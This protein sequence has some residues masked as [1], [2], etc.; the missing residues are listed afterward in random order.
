MQEHVHEFVTIGEIITPQ[1]CKG[2]GLQLTP[3]TIYLHPK[4][5]EALDWLEHD[6][7]KSATTILGHF[8][9]LEHGKRQRSAAQRIR[10]PKA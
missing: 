8:I 9:E 10:K 1:T 3:V 2:C 5:K 6:R 4:Q 7:K